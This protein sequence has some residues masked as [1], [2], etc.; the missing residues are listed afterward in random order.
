M[1]SLGVAKKLFLF[2]GLG[3]LALT[4][5]GED[6]SDSSFSPTTEP[7]SAQ[8][9]T[10]SEGAGLSEGVAG[11][12]LPTV[13]LVSVANG[14]PTDLASLVPSELPILAWFWAPHCP[15]C[16][17]EAPD[18]EAFAAENVDTLRV[19]GLGTQDDFA[20]AEEFVDKH[21]IENIEMFW[22]SGFESWNH[23][24]VRSQPTAIL[25]DTDGT[26][27][28]GWSGSFDEDKLLE[29]VAALS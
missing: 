24:E 16:N 22:E 13:E 20:E 4:A 6:G 21:G 14:E 1:K 23:F 11:A 10:S 5:C 27:I 25:L 18:V 15:S 12:A 2:V 3:S 29:E 26:P 7:A 19:V 28:I 9:S 8:E 17:A